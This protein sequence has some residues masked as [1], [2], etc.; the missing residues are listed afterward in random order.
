MNLSIPTKKKP[1]SPP[2]HP[3]INL[4]TI[5][6][7][8]VVAIDKAATAVMVDANFFMLVDATGHAVWGLA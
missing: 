4:N 2:Q 8:P 3:S 6:S 5:L 7:S 1:A